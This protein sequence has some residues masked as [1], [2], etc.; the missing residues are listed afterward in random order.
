MLS[1][2]A[3]C[4]IVL[5]IQLSTTLLS[6]LTLKEPVNL[7]TLTFKYSEECMAYNPSTE[8]GRQTAR[9]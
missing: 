4:F 5:F 3:A 2:S 7:L 8:A 9:A 6:F 1:V